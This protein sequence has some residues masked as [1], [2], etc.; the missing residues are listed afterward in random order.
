[1]VLHPHYKFKLNLARQTYNKLR[2]RVE[3][4]GKIII[5][6]GIV[7]FASMPVVTQALDL[8]P[9]QQAIFQQLS[10]DEQQMIRNKISG[11]KTEQSVSQPVVDQELVSPRAV[12]EVSKAKPDSENVY[13]GSAEIKNHDVKQKQENP[14]KLPQFGYELFAGIPST[15]APATEIPVPSDYVIGPG[16]TIL[17][18]LYGKKNVNYELQVSR[19][20][21]IQFPEIG[22]LAV[23]GLSFDELK[24]YINEVT[25]EQII[26][27]KASVTLGNLR[28][29]RIFVLGEAYRPG[30]YTVSALSTITNALFVSGGVT[31]AGS[32]RHVQLKRDGKLIGELDLYDLLLKGDTSSD[33]RLLPGDVI[34]IPPL[35]KTIGITGEVR[36]SAIYEIKNE[37][38]IKQVVNL[39]GG[40]LPTAFPAGTRIERITNA[41]NR[42]LVDV[43]LTTNTGQNSQIIDGDLIQIFPVLE[44]LEGAVLVKGHLHRPGGF[45]WKPRLRVSDVISSVSQLLPNPDLG[46]ALIKREKQP[47]RTITVISFS[48][49]DALNNPKTDQ[50][51]ALNSR[52]ELLIFGLDTQAR[53]A[54]IEPLIEQIKLQASV[55]KP[56]AY[57]T[58]GG[59]VRFPGDYP[60]A[61]AMRVKD[62]I[63][64]A[65][66]LTEQ[67]YAIEAEISRGIINDKKEQ[68]YERIQ[69]D[70]N[71]GD[72]GGMTSLV[73]RDQ[74]YIKRIPNWNEKESVVI[75]GEVNFPGTYPIYKGDKLVD[76]IKRAGGLTDYAEPKS[77]IFL[78]DDLRKR[79]AQ[80][81]ERMK[82][83]LERDM[84]NIKIE[85]AQRI[86]KN[87][88]VSALG[89][90]LLSELVD[91]EAQGR[92]VIRLADMLDG[93][94]NGIELKDKDRLVIP[95][96]SNEISVVGEIQFPTSH[97][98]DDKKDVFDYINISG[99]YTSRADKK[100]IYVIKASGEVAAVKNG[101]IIKRNVD[102][103]PGDTIVIP[104]DTYA[105]GNMTYW[106]NMSQILFQLATT[107]AALNSVGVF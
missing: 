46:Y 20:G 86:Q 4:L 45:T 38:T 107:T 89:E 42:T 26:G 78:R 93:K 21:T 51:P 44:K 31:K 58:V 74:L 103:E 82:K 8:S 33:Q 79:E 75:Q 19:E 24:G 36:R 65:G 37:Q 57:V 59:N 54:L 40:Y 13:S 81:L 72:Q 15:F 98:Y 12:N 18:Q 50:D 34:F 106:M 92:L 99:G 16:D 22:P 6:F 97:V 91:T 69:I 84:A 49:N 2:F 101:W 35:G 27:V 94:D 68:R 104:Y 96:K 85:S 67:A 9:E 17:V 102:V 87:Q 71:K 7:Y 48:L 1:M 56:A 80:Q 30:S 53:K 29:I 105:T 11:S 62:L 88:D 43:D 5:F 76:L 83:Q 10:P 60:L 77:A 39:A 100:R 95:R 64:A 3:Q 32:L 28:S 73:S 52:D 55:N 90:N 25:S 41:G 66:G 23:T 47:E 14:Q 63:A 61:T 70:L